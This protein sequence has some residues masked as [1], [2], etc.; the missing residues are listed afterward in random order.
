VTAKVV[1]EFLRD[2]RHRYPPTTTVYIMMDN[3]SVHWTKD[4]VASA[5]SNNV[6]FLPTRPTPT[7]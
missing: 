2:I 7:T 6:H 1:L 5:V 4:I 3:L